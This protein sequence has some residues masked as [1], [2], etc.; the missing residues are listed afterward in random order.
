MR[1]SAYAAAVPLA[2]SLGARCRLRQ[3]RLPESPLPATPAAATAALQGDAAL[4]AELSRVVAAQL[5]RLRL[6]GAV[7]V[8]DVPGRG[9]WR[10]ALGVRNVA[11]NESYAGG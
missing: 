4:A 11:T 8:V 9:A 10:A 3:H 2:L 6:P 5:T 7:V 1:R